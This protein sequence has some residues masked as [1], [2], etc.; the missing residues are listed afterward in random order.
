MRHK[1]DWIEGTKEKRVV[2]IPENELTSMAS[3]Q[4]AEQ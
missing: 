1:I 2:G 4:L 3:V